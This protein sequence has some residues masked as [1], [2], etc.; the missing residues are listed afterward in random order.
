MKELLIKITYTFSALLFSL[1][2]N[3]QANLNF[4]IGENVDVREIAVRKFHSL[5]VS[6][7]FAIEFTQ[8]LTQSVVFQG[9]SADLA[10]VSYEVKNGTL[11]IEMKEDESISV[12]G[13]EISVPEL[14]K[15]SAA[16]ANSFSSDFII[17]Q[18]DIALELSGATYLDLELHIKND[19]QMKVEGASIVNVDG[20]SENLMLDVA[21]VSKIAA[22]SLEAN[23]VTIA[24]TGISLVD[25][26]VLNELSVDIAG[27]S[28]VEYRG[29]PTV[30]SESVEGMSKLVRK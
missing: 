29:S 5:D 22:T 16:G 20:M 15:F 6:G 28:R 1:F 27:M 23:N 26:C 17:V 19:L 9:D 14:R 10:H 24:A 13:V 12:V 2:A 18:D 4:L 21:G 25:V 8:S 30:L 3:A 11:H 7:E